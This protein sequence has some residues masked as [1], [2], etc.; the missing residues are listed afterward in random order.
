MHAN[1]FIVENKCAPPFI[2]KLLTLFRL[3]SEMGIIAGHDSNGAGIKEASYGT[4][5][6]IPRKAEQAGW[7]FKA[8]PGAKNYKRTRKR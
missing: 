5:D 1:H 2:S 3:N 4:V 6:K 8:S 7:F